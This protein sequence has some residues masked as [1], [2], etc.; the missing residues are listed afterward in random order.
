MEESNGGKC[1]GY[2]WGGNAN[3]RGRGGSL[4]IHRRE[5]ARRVYEAQWSDRGTMMA[6]TERECVSDELLVFCFALNMHGRARVCDALAIP[7][8]SV[9]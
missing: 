4:C 7:P 3:K 8:F 6:C 2:A 5:A 9:G 1:I